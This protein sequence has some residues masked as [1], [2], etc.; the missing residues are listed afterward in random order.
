MKLPLNL[1]HITM[2]FEEGTRAVYFGAAVFYDG[3]AR[4]DLEPVEQR[5]V[6]ISRLFT[7]AM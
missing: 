1:R 6:L 5:V 7:T 2:A 4:T 3:V